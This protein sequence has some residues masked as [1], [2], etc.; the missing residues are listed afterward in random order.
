VEHWIM[1]AGT[2]LR[3]VVHTYKKKKIGGR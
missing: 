2:F 3:G 1:L